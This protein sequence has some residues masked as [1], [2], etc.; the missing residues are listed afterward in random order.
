MPLCFFLTSSGKHA[1]FPSPLAG[2]VTM[3]RACP[4]SNCTWEVTLTSVS[5]A[6]SNAETQSMHIFIISWQGMKHT[7]LPMSR[8]RAQP[9]MRGPS[10]GIWPHRYQQKSFTDVAL[11]FYQVQEQ[12]LFSV[13]KPTDIARARRSQ[14][15]SHWNA[16]PEVCHLNV[17]HEGYKN[18]ESMS[19]SRE[20]R[21]L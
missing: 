5:L 8:E 13:H 9:V 3:L 4:F 10:W 11:L 16:G 12:N 19:E 15:K 14:D 17:S 1:A 20:L 2:V 18:A 21:Q 6:I 7:T